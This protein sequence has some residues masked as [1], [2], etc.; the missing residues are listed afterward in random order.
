M[1]ASAL[2][3]FRLFYEYINDADL[4][5]AMAAEAAWIKKQEAR[6]AK[7]FGNIVRKLITQA[8]I[9]RLFTWL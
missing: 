2:D 7:N 8:G 9:Q 1:T 3:G 5:R 6:Q 4:E